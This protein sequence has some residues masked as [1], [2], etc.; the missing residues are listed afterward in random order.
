MLFYVYLYSYHINF[1]DLNR[2]FAVFLL[3]K[4]VCFC[5]QQTNRPT[6]PSKNNAKLLIFN[7]ITKLYSKKSDQQKNTSVGHVV[8]NQQ[9]LSDQQRP[10]ENSPAY[11]YIYY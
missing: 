7:H 1:E 11:Y 2:Q 8:N 3:Y 10:T 6:R 4:Y 5:D 9:N